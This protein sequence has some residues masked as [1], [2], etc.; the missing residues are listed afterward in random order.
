MS[1]LKQGLLARFGRDQRGNIAVMFALSLVPMLGFVGSAVDYSRATMVKGRL[2]SAVDATALKLTRDGENLSET[3]REAM[4]TRY[5]NA[6][7]DKQDTQG[8]PKL[9]LATTEQRVTLTANT[10]LAA[11]FMPLLGITKMD[12]SASAVSTYDKTKIELALVLD[13]TGSMDWSGKMTAL[14]NALISTDPTTGKKTGILPQIAGMNA[15]RPRIKVAIVPFDTQVN[16]GTSFAGT[17]FVWKQGGKFKH[18]DWLG[19][20]GE[21]SDFNFSGAATAN[22]KWKG[23]VTDRQNPKDTSADVPVLSQTET[24]YPAANCATGKLGALQPLTGDQTLL[25]NAVNA[26]QPSGMTNVAIGF[27]WGLRMLQNGTTPFGLGAATGTAGVKK[28]LV[29]L[30]DGD[31]TQNRFGDAQ[32]KIDD[33]T[34]A[35]CST[36]KAAPENITV[37]TV[38]VIE[39]NKSLLQD[40]ASSTKN[41]YEV[42]SSNDIAKAFQAILDDITGIRLAS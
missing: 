34:K 6:V 16:V 29:L 4:A 28:Y 21:G 17:D 13:N 11:V 30:T 27:H 25:T 26:M 33:R 3:D 37:Y 8:A 40:C 41:Y 12:V 20:K 7:F 42:N 5:F 22:D 35:M 38:R 31:N 39:G 10:N 19:F 23:C 15:Q 18:V 1:I 14:K 32:Y 2:Q 36:V 24:L 9:A